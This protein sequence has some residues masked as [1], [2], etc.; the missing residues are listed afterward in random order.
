MAD[1][2]FSQF[3]SGGNCQVGDIVVGLRNSDNAKFT[4]PGTGIE[5]SSGNFLIGYSSPG[6]SAV[7]YVFFESSNTTFAPTIS[8][9]GSDTN[10]NLD[11][12]SKGTGA[13]NLNGVS[14]NSLNSISGI[15]TA[16]FPGSSSGQV[17]LEAQSTAGT[18]TVQLPSTSGILA[19]ASALPTLPISLANGGT[20]ASLTASN[21]G[22]FYSNASTGAI[23]A[24]TATAGQL[25]QSGSSAAPTWSTATFAST[26]NASDLLFASASNTITGL[27]KTNQATLVTGTAGVPIWSNSM[28]DGQ[29]IIGSTAGQPQAASI[30]S[31]F[32]INV[33]P[34]PN[35]LTISSTSGG[36][37]LAWSNVAGTSQTAAV[38]SGYVTANSS[39]TTVTL[40]ATAALG[41]VIAVQGYG[42][43]KWVIQAPGAQVVHIGSSASSGGGSVSAANQYDS[44]T[45]VCVV[46]DSA[47]SLYGPVT[48]GYTIT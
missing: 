35:S 3:T 6:I 36:G 16:I 11:I 4:F 21:G 22:I 20:G 14:V 25:L 24:G 42:A 2:K 13:I 44:I 48:S 30:I 47:W 10:I 27:A 33:S 28:T 26:Y 18:P 29:V 7:N 1:I 45:L 46:A 23:L 38:N 15:T 41:S 5:D 37:G 12:E 32:G 19:L 34:G 40:P 39:L 31:G 43:G 9:V 17:I 8:S